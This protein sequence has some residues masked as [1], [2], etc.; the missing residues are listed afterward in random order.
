M[1]V[2]NAIVGFQRGDR[3]LTLGLGRTQPVRISPDDLF[4][5]SVFIWKT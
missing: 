4:K 5:V 1:I 3:A 2:L